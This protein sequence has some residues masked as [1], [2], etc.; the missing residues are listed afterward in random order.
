MNPISPA[1]QPAAA[2]AANHDLASAEAQ[3][4]FGFLADLIPQ[5]VWL[6]D[7]VGNHIYFNQRWTD[8]TGYGLAESVGPDM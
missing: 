8:F 7:P 5:L 3:D 1:G 6:T 2:P 4:Q